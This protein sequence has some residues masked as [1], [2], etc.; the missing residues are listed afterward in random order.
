MG[1]KECGVRVIRA[2]RGAF[3][4]HELHEFHELRPICFFGHRFIIILVNEIVWVLCN[5]GWTPSGSHNQFTRLGI[6][7][8]EHPLVRLG[9]GKTY[10]N[11]STRGFLV[12]CKATDLHGLIFVDM[13]GVEVA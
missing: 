4:G 6:R 10:K 12:V 1:S 7:L 11:E 9:I 2:I 13:T 5:Y 3:L 8:K